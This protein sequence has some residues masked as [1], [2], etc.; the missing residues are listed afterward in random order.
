MAAKVAGWLGGWVARCLGGKVS[1]WLAG[2]VSGLLGG[3]V[4]C[5]GRCLGGGGH[6][7]ARQAGMNVGTLAG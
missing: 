1:G 6:A 5:L 4:G 2:K 3:W 7:T